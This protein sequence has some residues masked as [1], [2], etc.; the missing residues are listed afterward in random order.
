MN[1][2]LARRHSRLSRSRSLS[3][4]ARVVS[5]LR[6]RLVFDHRRRRHAPRHIFVPTHSRF[7]AIDDERDRSRPSRAVVAAAQRNRRADAHQPFS[8]RLLH[9]RSIVLARVDADETHAIARDRFRVERLDGTDARAVEGVVATIRRFRRRSLAHERVDLHHHPA[10]F[11][12]RFDC[13]E[14]GDVLAVAL[15]ERHAHGRAEGRAKGLDDRSRAPRALAPDGA[16]RVGDAHGVESDD[17][18]GETVARHDAR[19]RRSSR[20]VRR[21]ARCGE[22]R[23]RSGTVVVVVVVVLRLKNVLRC[24]RTRRRS[25]AFTVTNSARARACGRDCSSS[26]TSCSCR[27][28]A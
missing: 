26:L 10:P 16:G 24:Y 21:A 12:P 9:R 28:V 15:A 20:T 8:K 5:L 18:V 11:V 25:G 1:R 2:L 3:R 23:A 7:D 4:R 27:G 13:A 22:A 6:S 14:V 17:G 19:A